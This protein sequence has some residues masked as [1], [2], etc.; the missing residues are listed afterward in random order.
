MAGNA[1]KL[2]R[3]DFL[4]LG[5]IGASGVVLAACAAPAAAPQIVKETVVV[6]TEKV[7]EQTVEVVKEVEKE[8]T[9]KE[10][11]VVEQEQAVLTIAHAWE[12]AF[13]DVQIKYDADFM[14]RHPDIFVKQINSGWAQ[15]N[16][17]VPTW[18]AAG[19]LPDI[20]Y[21]HGSRAFPWNFEGIMMPNQDYIDNDPEFNVEDVWEEARR[22]YA[23][24]GKQYEI[25]YDHGPMIMGYNKD[26]FDAASEPYPAEDWTMDD[27]LAKAKKL[28]KD[29]VWGYS[30]YYGGV[31]NL[32]N[33]YGIALVGPFGGAVFNDEETE[34]LIDTPEAKAGLQFF[35][36]MIHVDKVSPTPSVSQSFP[37]G[38]WI[39]GNAAMFGLATWGVPQMVEFG[40]FNWDVAPWPK[41]PKAQITGSFG[42]GYGTTRD[43]KF[44]DQSW[45]YLSEYLS[46]E[47][48]EYMWGASGRGSPARKSAYQ[49][50]LDSEIAPEHAQYYLD[51]LDTYALTGHPYHNLASGELGDIFTRNTDLMQTGDITVDEAVNNI[52]AE[53]DPVMKA[54]EAKMKGG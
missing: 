54:A 26:L 30:G 1:R 11:V 15:H 50:Y 17:I 13:M 3:R 24:N 48:M 5:S 36:D 52:M 10:T 42:S 47:G 12:A 27:F 29:P 23:L 22:L 49:S 33:E 8:V 38:I 44:P 25:P 16:Q 6:E 40:D 51:A 53:A 32:G 19:E 28:T 46:K 14:A 2:T 4:K 18:A 20:I 43:S 7:V 35:T 21:V 31:A 45:T 37:A 41:G 39:A 9:V 34:L